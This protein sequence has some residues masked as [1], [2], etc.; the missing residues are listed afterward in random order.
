MSR[1]N[2]VGQ[3][4]QNFGHFGNDL[5]KGSDNLVWSFG[6]EFTVFGHLKNWFGQLLKNFGQLYKIFGQLRQIFGQ[7][8]KNFG[9][10]KSG[11]S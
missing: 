6:Q 7:E 4:T 9:H 8:Y 2:W 1:L 10:F 5:D 3:N 11:H